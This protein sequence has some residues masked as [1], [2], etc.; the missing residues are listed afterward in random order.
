MSFESP[1]PFRFADEVEKTEITQETTEQL[2]QEQESGATSYLQ[3]SIERMRKKS[4]YETEPAT[5]KRVLE[6]TAQI[7]NKLIL[8]ATQALVLLDEVKKYSDEAPI[9]A[10]VLESIDKLYEGQTQLMRIVSDVANIT[11]EISKSVRPIS[12]EEYQQRLQQ[13]K[14]EEEIHVD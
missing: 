14:E 12:H 4:S 1:Q 3:D 13:L 2:D 9:S 11:T 6:F 7:G 10:E 8:N 5:P